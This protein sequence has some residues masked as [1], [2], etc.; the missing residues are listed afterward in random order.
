VRRLKRSCA[1]AENCLMEIDLQEIDLIEI[2]N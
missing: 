1:R 2:D